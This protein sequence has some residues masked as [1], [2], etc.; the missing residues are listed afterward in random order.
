[1]KW[2]A[3]A[4]A[5]L[6]AASILLLLDPQQDTELMFWIVAQFA[7]LICIDLSSFLFLVQRVGSRADGVP[8]VDQSD[9]RGL[10][11]A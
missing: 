3:V 6:K 2:G 8:T 4:G 5:T 7:L 1:L 11:T 9:I 10:A